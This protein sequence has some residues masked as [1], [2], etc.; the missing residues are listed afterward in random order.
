MSDSLRPVT[1]GNIRQ[2]SH[3]RKKGTHASSSSPSA[4]DTYTPTSGTGKT[5]KKVSVGQ[6]AD[7]VLAE[8]YKPSLVWEF[9]A[10][11]PLSGSIVRSPDGTIFA[12]TNNS[13]I[14][15]LDGKTGK[16]KWEFDTQGGFR[17][18]ELAA[19]PDGSLYTYTLDPD[20]NYAQK[21]CALDKTDGHVKWSFT[22]DW[23]RFDP[24]VGSD[25]TVY[26]ITDEGK[27][28]ALDPDS[29]KMKWDFSFQADKLRKNYPAISPDGM[30]YVKD[31]EG[32][33]TAYDGP[34]G[35][36]KWSRKPDEWI[37]TKP[38]MTDEGTV[39][40]DCP[41]S[42]IAL[43]GKTGQIRWKFPLEVYKGFH[44]CF[45]VHSF[46]GN[47]VIHD[48]HVLYV[49]D[50]KTGKKKC[51]YEKNLADESEPV[52]SPYGMV[53]FGTDDKKVIAI[54]A[55]T[56]ELRWTH[57]TGDMVSSRPSAGFDGTVL[58]GCKN[59]KLYAVRDYLRES[60]GSDLLFQKEASQALQADDP[61]IHQE[62]G[63]VL[64]D[65]VRLPKHEQ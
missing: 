63:Y 9:D 32:R 3:R 36:K 64:I 14:Y 43:D 8:S 29:G 11:D 52:V 1:P 26:A 59:G 48:D 34:T 55:G 7:R 60:M 13:R 56:G 35:K 21:L 65:G 42:V 61:A 20:D 45:S 4:G 37:Q 44:S 25:G 16:K 50:S 58:A 15:A 47:C 19:G 28:V 49:L 39:I 51:R 27:I 30:I 24:V 33:I 57:E 23:P 62:D 22:L 17:E 5:L 40:L 54:D 53:Y 38:V 2:V 41:R 18:P 10:G 6:I 31:E 12:G 46:N